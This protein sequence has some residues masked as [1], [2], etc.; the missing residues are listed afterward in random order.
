MCRVRAHVGYRH[1]MRAPSALHRLAVDLLRPRPAFRRAKHDHRPPWAL[2]VTVETGGSLDLVDPIERDAEHV[3]E[4]P[5]GIDV[6][7]V[8]ADRDEEGLMAVPAHQGGELVL[9]NP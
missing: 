1:L 2:A 3:S 4:A 6:V 8:R 9:R 5:V 7:V